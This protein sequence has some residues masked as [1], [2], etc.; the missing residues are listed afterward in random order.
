MKSPCAF[1]LL[2]VAMVVYSRAE[3]L[4]LTPEDF[5]G[6]TV[7]KDKGAFVEFYAP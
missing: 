1:L 5:G 7:G 3:V 6:K 4:E 2:L